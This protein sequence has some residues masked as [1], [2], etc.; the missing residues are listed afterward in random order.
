MELQHP[1]K[2]R[3][4]SIENRLEKLTSEL[5]TIKK[6]ALQA[7]LIDNADF[8]KLMNISSSTAQNWRNKG[9]I[10]YSQIENKIYYKVSDIE[11]LLDLHYRPFKRAN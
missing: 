6:T 5:S 11:Q 7:L 9:I 1:N 2:E 4:K 10:A 8:L 3:L